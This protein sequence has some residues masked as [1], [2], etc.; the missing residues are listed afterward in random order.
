MVGG[1]WWLVGERDGI[2]NAGMERSVT[3]GF[4]LG[5]KRN[6]YN[7]GQCRSTPY[8]AALN[9]GSLLH[10]AYGYMLLYG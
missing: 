1:G 2:G 4:Q 9:K 7:R 6:I 5:R 10:H 3:M 8:F